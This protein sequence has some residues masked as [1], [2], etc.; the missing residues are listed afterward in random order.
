MLKLCFYTPLIFII[1]TPNLIFFQHQYQKNVYLCTQNRREISS[2]C[3]KSICIGPLT[4]FANLKNTRT[5]ILM[6]FAFA[7]LSSLHI[8][9]HRI[10]FKV[11]FTCVRR[12]AMPS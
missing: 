5:R 10:R 11:S 8:W 6:P 12:L 3:K 1:F 2:K 4:E 7:I 9:G